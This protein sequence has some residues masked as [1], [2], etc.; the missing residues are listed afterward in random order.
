MLNETTTK[1]ENRIKEVDLV[2]S[3]I[4]QIQEELGQVED[5]ALM[6]EYSQEPLNA[7]LE[8]L[9]NLKNKLLAEKRERMQKYAGIRKVIEALCK[10]LGEINP[11]FTV[12]VPS[13]EAVKDDMP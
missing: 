9:V 1:L 5:E 11:D 2:K 4:S 6:T 12:D 10:E 7:Q 8:H 13:L 3:E